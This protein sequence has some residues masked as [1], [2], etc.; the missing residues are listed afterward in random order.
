[1]KPFYEFRK[2]CLIILAGML[3][4]SLSGCSG[5]GNDGQVQSNQISD[6]IEGYPIDSNVYTTLDR[7]VEPDPV[8]SASPGINVYDVSQYQQ[9]GY[10]NWHFNQ[11]GISREKRP[12][13]MLSGYTGESTV[14]LGKLMNFFTISDIHITDK[15]T[16]AQLIYW[17]GIDGVSSMYSAVMLYTTQVLDS[18]VQTL[19]VLNQKN[20][21]DFGI[22]L[23]DTCNSTEYNELRWYLD[24]IDGQIINPDSGAKDDPVPGPYNDYQDV[25]KA[26]GFDKSIRWY[27][28]MGN[29]DHFWIGSNPVT[30]YLR[31]FYTG[32]NILNMGNVII[33]PLGVNSRGYYMGCID[34][35]TVYGDVYGAGPVADFPTPPTI[36]AADPNR[37]SITRNEWI[38]EFFNTTTSPVG[39]GFNQTNVETGFACYSFEPKSNIPLKMIVLDDTMGDNDPNVGG[40]GHADLDEERYNWLVNELDEGQANNKLMIIAMHC[41][42]GVEPV[43]SPVGWS[44]TA[45]VTEPDLIAKLHTYPNLLMIIAGHRHVNAVTPFISPDANHPEL[46]FWQVETPSLRDY[47]QQPRTFEIF[48]NNDKTISILATDVDTAVKEGSL[49]AISRSYAVA[50]QEFFN[51]QIGYLPYGSY[52]CELYKQLTPEMQ[53]VVSRLKSH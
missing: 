8:P 40:Y 49:A 32:V 48:V 18:A 22:S 7:A 43:G 33:D 31:P 47:P 26:A 27:Q 16:G 36:L 51:N 5:N 3:I 28:T 46:G 50:A 34:G 42:I 6:Q 38:N 37:R 45:F 23:G 4:F 2:F 15:E 30:D 10:G 1:M 52:N 17:G 25:Y 39:H 11:Q 44:T 29:H 53:A 19:N 41:P 35:R 20:T 12:D 14:N 24:V 21:F 13:I 9:Y